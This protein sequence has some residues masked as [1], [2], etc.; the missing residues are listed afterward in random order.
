MIKGLSRIFWG[1]I[2]NTVIVGP[3]LGD[4]LHTVFERGKHL[5]ENELGAKMDVRLE[6]RED[7]RWLERGF[8]AHNSAAYYDRSRKAVAIDPNKCRI[9]LAN[10]KTIRQKEGRLLVLMLHE[11]LHAYQELELVKRE[12]S[13]RVS[14]RWLR[15]VCEGHSLEFSE[16][17]AQ[18]AGVSLP[19]EVEVVSWNEP[20]SRQF[21]Q[22]HEAFLYNFLYIKSRTYVRD[23]CKSVT[24]FHK[25]LQRQPSYSEVLTHSDKRSP[26][27]AVPEKY[28]RS[29][30]LKDTTVTSPIE[31]DYLDA[32]ALLSP[33]DF[34]NEEMIRAFRGG[35]CCEIVSR[36]R[37]ETI[38]VHYEPQVVS[39]RVYRHLRTQCVSQFSERH[40]KVLTTAGLYENRTMVVW[41]EDGHQN[42]AFAVKL[43]GPL[44]IVV[45]FPITE[46]GAKLA[47]A[48][49]DQLVP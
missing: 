19:R 18:E 44:V 28:L 17:L 49:L 36:V 9:L 25:L 46:D 20:K 35:N 42:W 7:T 27:S 34:E 31:F 29:V 33:K 1:T 47:K 11:L 30:R 43:K 16:K 13:I 26:M 5:L 37:V 4:E 15:F 32:S 41:T 22:V 3:S 40:R 8:W 38:V 6:I 23:R 48:V 39:D 14:G 21:G 10:T 45:R 24:D 2:L 12:K